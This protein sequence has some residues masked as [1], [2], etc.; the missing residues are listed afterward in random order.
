MTDLTDE[1]VERMERAMGR[2][3]ELWTEAVDRLGRAFSTAL[4]S[5]AELHGEE[6]L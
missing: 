4:A 2:I 3:V 6:P 1:Q 5:W